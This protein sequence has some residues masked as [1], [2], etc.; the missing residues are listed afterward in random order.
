MCK[1]LAPFD[2]N[3]LSGGYREL[4]IDGLDEF[5]EPKHILI[6]YHIKKKDCCFPYG[7]D[8]GRKT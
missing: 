6:D 4:G 1:L 2:G 7:M 5:R 8:A 3:K